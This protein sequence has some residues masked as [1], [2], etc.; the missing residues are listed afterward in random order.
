M[1]CEF[2]R[3]LLIFARPGA[4]ELEAADVAALE[5]HLADCVDCRAR[6][7]RGTGYGTFTAVYGLAWLAGAALIGLF[8]EH[9]TAAATWFVVVV[10]AFAALLLLPLLSGRSHLT[11]DK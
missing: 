1:D 5:G 3:Q 4:T 9:G 7:R 11:S 8:Y 10:Q 6:S 2:A